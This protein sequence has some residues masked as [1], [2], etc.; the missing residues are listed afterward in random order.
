MPNTETPTMWAGAVE[1]QQPLQVLSQN[2]QTA[3]FAT[4]NF[5]YDLMNL[6]Q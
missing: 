6:K 5:F 3:I 2:L 4:I 1:V